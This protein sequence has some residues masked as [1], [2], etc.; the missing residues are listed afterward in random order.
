MNK[1]I[2][3][4]DLSTVCSGYAIFYNKDLLVYDRI[5]PKT[6]LD[7]NERIEYM[8]H[9]FAKVF[10]SIKKD[11]SDAEMKFIIENIYLAFFRGKNQVEGFANLG[12]ISGAIMATIFLVLGKDSSHITLRPA[13]SARPMVGMKGNCQKA[14]VQSWVILNFTDKDALDY[15]CLIDAVYAEQFS[16]EISKAVFKQRMGE[17]SKI[18]EAETGFGEDVS[19]AILLG[20]GEVKNE[21]I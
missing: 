9:E 19:D 10:K 15:E 5:K 11:F 7:V 13:I 6:T 8:T 20:Y 16:G 1:L 4:L 17:I 21:K 2:I 14:E 12:R 18:I 3:G